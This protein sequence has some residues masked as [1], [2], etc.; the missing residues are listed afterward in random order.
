MI[1]K[2]LTLNPFAGLA[3]QTI[4]FNPGLNIFLGPNEKGKSTIVKAIH[5]LLFIEPSKKV[6]DKNMFSEY[7]PIGGGDTIKAELEFSVNGAEYS[8]NKS[9][10]QRNSA[11][12]KLSDNTLIAKYESIASKIF[13]FLNVS[14]LTYENVLVVNQT[15][16]TSTIEDIDNSDIKNDITHILRT[17]LFQT[18]G[19][20]IDKFKELIEEKIEVYYANW[21]RANEK[22]R[23]NK[24][25]NNPWIKGNGLIINSFYKY[26]KLEKELE[27]IEEYEIKID[28][29]N[30]IITEL[31]DT[32]KDLEIFL[33]NNKKAYEDC[34]KRELVETKVANNKVQT[35]K[36]KNAEENWP[37]I[38][39]DLEHQKSTSE[40]LAEKINELNAQKAKAIDIESKKQ[41]ADK[42][43]KINKL[44][45]YLIESIKEK[46]LLTE[47]TADDVKKCNGIAQNIAK[48]KIKLDAQKLNAKIIAKSDIEG[49]IITGTE[50]V[51][52]ISLKGGDSKEETA[53]GRFIYEDNM[54]KIEVSSGEVNI[55]ELIINLSK[56]EKEHDELLKA[57]KVNSLE[58]LVFL[59]EKNKT[60]TEKINNYKSRIEEELGEDTL[61]ELEKIYKEIQN[62]NIQRTSNEIGEEI[63]KLSVEAAKLEAE[64]DKNK[65]LIEEYEEE[66]GNRDTL[67]EKLVALKTEADALNAD[68][69]GLSPLPE[70]FFDSNTFVQEYNNCKEKYYNKKDELAG[71]KQEK[72]YFERYKPDKTQRETEEE[73]RDAKKEFEKMKEEGEAILLIKSTIESTLESFGKDTYKPLRDTVMKYLRAS[74]NSHY[75]EIK[76]EELSA[77]SLTRGNKEIPVG[78][79]STGTKDLLGL[80][81]RLSMAEFYLKESKGFLIMDD[82]LVNLDPQRQK[83]AVE[84]IKEFSKEKQIIIMTCHPSHA[85]MFNSTVVNL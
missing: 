76:L 81:L 45:N 58:E 57:F 36:I 70:G 68:L 30:K 44:N 43:L 69:E 32:C 12:L 17:A 16:L 10:G 80:I 52:Q 39:A 71:K 50:E 46:D 24:D 18:G 26:R 27:K 78:L 66:F 13:E 5:A 9:W 42:Y 8:L 31:A 84:L 14:Q 1:L 79:L 2:K 77:K 38:E 41:K 20:S 61:E 11:E 65:E 40:K 19:I 64:I 73:L 63:Q 3:N 15:K 37:R 34:S 62:T 55:E 21:E 6:K 22:P 25:I 82:P 29:F 59:G 60:M 28:E 83:K 48:I 67:I 54:L 75:C 56:L 23:G 33:N 51:K 47:V 72:A 53:S 4:E 74:V 35:E 7:L 49:K 85:D